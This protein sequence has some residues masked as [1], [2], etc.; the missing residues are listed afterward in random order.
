MEQ[1]AD[2]EPKKD[3]FPA[4]DQKL[5]AVCGLFCEACSLYIATREEPARLTRL[6][7]QFK[8]TE[9]EVACLGCRAGKRGPYCTT[10]HM[11]TCARKRGVDFCSQCPDYPCAELQA[12]QAER[13]HRLELWENLAQIREQGWQ[14]WA[15]D[16]R[17]HY[18]CPACGTLN[19]AYDFQCRT[20]GTE[21]S[22]GYVARH[23]EAVRDFLARR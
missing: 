5:A 14:R 20:C 4:P 23:G 11:A 12:F 9:E 6:A 8:L 22:C 19:S 7:A 17:R 13:P 1:G 15:T 2:M 16:M 18:A 10:C 21:P 3:G